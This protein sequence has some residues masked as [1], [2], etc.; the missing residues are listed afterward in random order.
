MAVAVTLGLAM[1][2]GGG[3]DND[4]SPSNHSQAS[5]KATYADIALANY[6]ES[7]DQAET[8]QKAIE[9][10]VGDPTA[11]NLTAA[12][13]AWKEARKAYGETEAYRLTLDAASPIDGTAVGGVT[14]EEGPEGL[15]NAWP[16]EESYIDYT[17]DFADSGLVNDATA[18]SKITASSLEDLSEG[19]ALAVGGSSSETDTNVSVGY[20]AIEF[21][22]WGQDFEDPDNGKAGARTFEDYVDEGTTAENEDRRRTY[23]TEATALLITHLTQLR[24]AWAEDD[25]NY[26]STFLAYT[27]DKA[28]EHMLTGVGSLANAE[29]AEERMQVALDEGA[30]GAANQEHEHS[31]FSDTT[32]EDIFRNTQGIINILNG[33]YSKVD[34]SNVISGTSLADITSDS[35][36]SMALTDAIADVQTKVQAI[37][38]AAEDGEPF[39]KQILS[40][41]TDGTTRVG[42]AIT[43]LK[44]L[45]TAIAD[46][47][48]NDF[49][50]NIT[51]TLQD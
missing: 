44:A 25:D 16:L 51:T 32:H 34:G 27:D 13:N 35:T 36:R 5:Y 31:C 6:Q 22:L 49:S 3:G 33:T 38:D 8:M 46:I 1:A 19:D 37:Y 45:A 15:L 24:D 41:N 39:D 30:G 23:L 11:N 20:H 40:T 43:S 48:T 42:A 29:L 28:M 26:R 9:T 50:L 4:N 7:L 10:F 21:L 18:L 2:C 47:T 17:R 14:G 12:Q